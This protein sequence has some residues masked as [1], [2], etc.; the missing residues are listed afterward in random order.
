MIG[1][2]AVKT[3]GTA[4]P[5][6]SSIGLKLALLVVIGL[7]AC[8]LWLKRHGEGWDMPPLMPLLILGELPLMTPAVPL[9]SHSAEDENQQGDYQDCPDN[10]NSAARS[11]S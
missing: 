6:R 5:P 3:S 7:A 9:Q 8:I 2:T 4:S 11:P 10:P 1:T